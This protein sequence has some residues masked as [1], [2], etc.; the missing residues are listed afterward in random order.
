MTTIGTLT[1][2]IMRLLEGGSASTRARVGREEV[3]HQLSAAISSLMKAQ[4]L[5]TNFSFDGDSI[6]DGLMVA[7]YEKIPVTRRD[8]GRCQAQLP[9]SP[10]VLPKGIGVFSV[11]P[12]GQ[13]SKEYIPL[14]TGFINLLSADKLLNPLASKTYSVHGNHVVI[15]ADIVG[16]GVTELDMQLCVMDISKYGDYDVLPI[17]GDIEEQAMISVLK[18]FGLIV[19]TEKADNK[20]LS[21]QK[22]DL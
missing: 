7:T 9:V 2:R 18:I 13:P 10:M 19:P 14:R 21:P 4:V 16:A 15:H 1:E 5:E 11:Y 12:T 20:A 8:Q 17:P 22:S 6:P 3:K